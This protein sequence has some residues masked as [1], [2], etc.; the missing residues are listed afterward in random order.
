M[1]EASRDLLFAQQVEMD[2]EIAWG[3][4]IG[5]DRSTRPTTYWQWGSNPGF[6][7][8]LI[9]EPQRGDAIVVLT[10][11][12]TLGDLV[13]GRGG[14]AAAKQIARRALG[15]NGRWDLDRRAPDS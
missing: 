9:V 4:G 10:N 14:Y 7:S 8:L 11:R 13:T 5:I 15:I 2:P 12:G 6:Q 1:R 3:A